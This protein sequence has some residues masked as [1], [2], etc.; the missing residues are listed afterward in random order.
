ME[1]LRLEIGELEIGNGGE[2]IEWDEG[3]WVEGVQVKDLKNQFVILQLV[4]KGV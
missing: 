2:V 1:K 3:W 4:R